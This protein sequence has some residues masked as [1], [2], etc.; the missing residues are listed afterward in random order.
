M[1]STKTK[2]EETA[3]LTG[4]A[5]Q[6]VV[7]DVVTTAEYYRDVLGFK[8]FGYWLDPPVYAIVKRDEAE[9]HFGKQ[10]SEPKANSAFRECAIDAYIRTADIDALYEELKSSGAEIIEEL[11]E[12]AYA[13]REFVV[14]DCN[15]YTLAFGD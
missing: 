5:P 11:T 10:D 6:F 12:R 9:I 8:I 15:G 4:I 1:E 3:T 13:S 2:K 14:R 7:A